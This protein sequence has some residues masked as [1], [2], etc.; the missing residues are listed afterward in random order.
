[1][2]I[3]FFGAAQNV[4]GSKHVIETKNFKLLLDCGLYQGRRDEANKLNRNF[5]FDS[6]TIS[7]VILSHA[8]ADHCGLLPLL[9]K[10]GFRGNIYCTE[11]TRDI[12]RYIL[13]DS[14]QIQEHDCRYINQ[15]LDS[16]REPLQPLYTL[17][18]VQ[19]VLPLFKVVEYFRHTKKWT[20][21][22]NDFRFKFYDAGHIL[23]SAITVIEVKD[24]GKI[25]NI[26]YSGDLGQSNVP[27]LREPEIITESVDVFLIEATYGDRV[28][29]PIKNASEKI[30]NLVKKIIAQKGKIIVPA[31]SLGRTQELVYLLH[32]LIN[33]GKI[34]YLP[35]YV[36]SPLSNAI[37]SVF[38][39]HEEN[40]DENVWKDFGIHKESA[41]EFRDLHYV[42]TVDDSKKIN[43]LNG[44][45]IVVSA[46]GMAEAGRVLHHLKN[47]IQNKNNAILITGF[48]AENTLGRKIQNHES[49]VKI[50]DHF[51]K[52]LAEVVTVDELSAH[53]DKNGL[54][55]YLSLTK[56]VEKVFLVHT[57][58]SPA[59][60]FRDAI[61]LNHP[62]IDVQ[63]PVLG[64]SYEI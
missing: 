36:D 32:K 45:L 46:S 4:T 53:A 8:H 13:E 59:E 35:I 10:N 34:P 14:A 50:Y 1:M 64:Q 17:D 49:P 7:A 11:E 31:F 6:K 3:S 18:D 29:S 5:L 19:K 51:Y 28:H 47:N 26:A 54:M 38:K 62:G 23:G 15:H 33:E 12:A 21:L 52:V 55:K 61:K 39:E 43:Y 16:A 60:S 22:N 42:S 37:S 56:G 20:K 57:E 63:I 9:V 48:Q 27:I 58:L 44:P 41:F 2:K 24:N 30:I 25:K 40:F